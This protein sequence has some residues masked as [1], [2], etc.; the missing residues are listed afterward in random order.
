MPSDTQKIVKTL[1]D[2]M[3][4]MSSENSAVVT[5]GYVGISWEKTLIWTGDNA[6]P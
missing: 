1:T 2:E 4:V 5:F 6:D 3:K